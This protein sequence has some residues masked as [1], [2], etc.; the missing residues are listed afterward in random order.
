MKKKL[1][2]WFAATLTILSAAALVGC[3][4]D[5]EDSPGLEFNGSDETWAVYWYAC[6]SD[7]ESDYGAASDDIKEL[8]TVELPENVKFIIETGGSYYWHHWDIMGDGQERY[9]YDDSGELQLVDSQ[10]QANMGESQ[11]FADFLEFCSTNY[12]ADHT[13]VVFWNHGGGSLTGVAYDELYDYDYLS[14]A[15]I[16]EGFSQVYNLSE[17][18]PPIDIV[19]F[20]TCLMGSIDTAYALSDVAQYMVA[21]EEM[22]PG[23]GWAYDLWPQKLGNNPGMDG[24]ELGTIICD[25]YQEACDYYEVGDEITMSVI[26]L[27]NASN[28][29]S[30]YESMGVEALAQACEDPYF[31]A[32]FGRDAMR[33]ENYGGN[34]P[35]QGYSNMVDLGHLAENAMDI[36]PYTA[37]TVLDA[38]DECVVHKING[39]YRQEASGLSCYYSYDNDPEMLPY[40]SIN[41]ASTT[42]PSLYNY[43]LTGYIS[44]ES[45]AYIAEYGYDEPSYVPDINEITSEFDLEDYPLYINDYGNGVLDLGPDIVA[46][47]QSVHF[48]LAYYDIEEDIIIMMGIDNDI[49]ADWDNGVFT[50]NFRGVWGA[51]DDC[52][53][54]MEIVYEGD[55]Y[56]LYSVP[57]LLNGEEYNLHVGYDFNVE[58]FE[59]LGARK[60]IPSE[61]GMADKNLRRLEEGDEITTLH[62]ASVLSDDSDEVQ[63]PIDTFTV[64]EDTSFT[65]MDVGDGDFMMMFDMTDMQGNSYLSDILYLTVDGD[66]IYAETD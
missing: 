21:S 34:T 36:L 37:Q 10:P 2:R 8:E 7:L 23:I 62:Y 14:L 51:I 16:Y 35:D 56:N 54:Y 41:S 11:T 33:S 18:D 58:E 9:L 19:G 24:A 26:D 66:N 32:E 45:L 50:E 61:Y 38:L 52:F 28:L 48:I 22:A 46:S 40:Y 25:T 27:Q 5:I 6:G 1:F 31:F 15:E 64:T 43:G 13:M 3:L 39:P 49:D 60:G 53:C 29:F 47:L 20:D 65:E 4:D 57:I 44:D 17:E 30:A 63:V 42:F 55:D 12:P 59:I